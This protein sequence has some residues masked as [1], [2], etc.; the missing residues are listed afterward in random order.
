[1]VKIVIGTTP[2]IKYNFK[3]I[4]PSD[5]HEAILTIVD[6]AKAEKVRKELDTA[7]VGT[8]SIEWVLTQAETLSLGTGNNLF[9]MLNW[10]TNDGTRG[11]SPEEIVVGVNNHIREVLT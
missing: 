7:T 8:D 2:T 6:R 9:M 10:L 5:L 4:K 11:A 1:M 3:V